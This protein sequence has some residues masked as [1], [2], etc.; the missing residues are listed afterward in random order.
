MMLIN[1]SISML[2]SI[3][4]ICVYEFTNL[5]NNSILLLVGGALIVHSTSI[6]AYAR[7]HKAA[8]QMLLAYVD[9]FSVLAQF[10]VFICL[11]FNGYGLT[12][13]GVALLIHSMTRVLILRAICYQKFNLLNSFSLYNVIKIMHQQFISNMITYANSRLDQIILST[14]L[15]SESFG[16]F[17]FLK[18]LIVYP[19]TLLVAIYTQIFFPYFSRNRKNKKIV[20][21]LVKIILVLISGLL[22]YFTFLAIIP[23]DFVISKISYWDFRSPLAFSLLCYAICKLSFDII[24]PALTAV[25]GISQQ[26]RLNALIFTSLCLVGFVARFLSVEVYLFFNATCFIIVA[27]I[28]MYKFIQRVSVIN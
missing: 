13:F 9:L 7:L 22:M 23:V 27:I 16:Y 21:K 17:S 1:I 15:S 10:L 3:L 2:L 4:I 19:M 28:A 11:I 24:M 14:I 6:V 5:K 18:Q 8:R 12:T 25:G 20:T 26:L